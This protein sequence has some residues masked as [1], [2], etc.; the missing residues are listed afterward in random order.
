MR[1][2]HLVPLFALFLLFAATD[3]YAQGASSVED[4]GK[5]ACGSVDLVILI[6]TTYS[7]AAAIGEMKRESDTIVSQLEAVSE[8]KY[9]LG[10]IAFDDRIRVLEDLNDIPSPA[11]KANSMR[12]SIRSL[13]AEGGEGGPEASDEAMNTAINSL[14]AGTRPQEGDFTGE[15]K[16]HSRILVLITDSRPGG[17]DDEFVTGV[18]DRRALSYVAQALAK[19]IHISAIQVPT[20]GFSD[21][22]DEE[23]AALMRSYAAAT[24]GLYASTRWAGAGTAEAVLSIIKACGSNLLS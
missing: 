15:W 7:L 2:R 24:G 19:D 11:A 23:V 6:D 8:G 18:D 20:G 12:R 16:A 17:F 9:R 22:P 1:P 3:T 13:R 4:P 5:V 21:L 10:L 14:V